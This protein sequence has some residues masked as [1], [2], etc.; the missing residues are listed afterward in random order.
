MKRKKRNLMIKCEQSLF[1]GLKAEERL[2]VTC[3][4]FVLSVIM[5]KEI[6]EYVS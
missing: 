3:K 5:I 4:C 1:I 6:I 2:T